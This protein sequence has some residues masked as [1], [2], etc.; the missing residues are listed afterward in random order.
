MN[1]KDPTEHPVTAAKSEPSLAQLRK[2]A[3]AHVAT[4]QSL[5]EAAIAELSPTQIKTLV[6]E[7]Q[8]HQVELTQQNEALQQTQTELERLRTRYYDLYEQAPVG[9][10]TV[11]D[12]GIIQEANR[13]A[14]TLLGL[15]RYELVGRPLSRFIRAQDKV[16]DF[17]H[18]RALFVSGDP[19]TYEIKLIKPNGETF[20]ARFDTSL[21]Q[22]EDFTPVSRVTISDITRRR[23]S[24]SALQASEAKFRGIFDNLQDAVFLH[25]VSE[26]QGVGR[27]LDVNPAACQRLGYTP[28]E[29]RQLTPRDVEE[30][31]RFEQHVAEVMR[32]LHQQGYALFETVH[33]AKDGRRIPVENHTRLFDIGEQRLALTIS[34]DIA[35]RRQLLHDLEERIKELKCLHGIAESIR[36]RTDIDAICQDIVAL[37]PPGWHY[38][39]ITRGKITLAD[40]VYVTEPFDETPWQLS[41]EIVVSGQSEGTVEVYYLRE[42][43]ELDEGPFLHE[44]RQLIDSIA[45]SLG[46]AIER[47]R[48]EAQYRQFKTI[49]DFAV[50]GTGIAGLDGTLLYVNESFARV[51]GY[52]P[53]ELIGRNLSIF[54]SDQQLSAVSRVNKKLFHEGRFGP[55]EIGHIHRDGSE[56]PMLMSGILIRD[57]HNQPQY[58]AASAVDIRERKQAEQQL[59]LINQHLQQQIARANQLAQQAETANQAKSGFLASMSHEIRTPINAIIG[60]TGLLLDT[61]LSPEQHQYADTVRSSSQALL[62][63]I[64]DILDLSKIEAGK[65]ELDDVIFDLPKLLDEL[66]QIIGA[67]ARDKGLHFHC[68]TEP[69]VP[70]QLQGDPGRLRQILINLASNAVKFTA[71]GQVTVRVEL[72]EA[73]AEGTRLRFIVRDTGIGIPRAKQDKLFKNFS[74]IDTSTTRNFGGTGLG[75]AIAKQLTDAMGGEIG[76]DSEAD[77]GADFWFT[78][79][80]QRARQAVSPPASAEPPAKAAPAAAVIDHASVLVVDDNVINLKVAAGVL[81]KL[82]VKAEAVESGHAALQALRL[83]SFDMVLMDVEM[84]DMDGLSAT[85]QIRDP[86][87]QVLNPRIPVIALTAHAMAG[88]REKCLAAGMDGYVPK[89]IEPQTLREVIERWL[90]PSR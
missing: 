32:E 71:A 46:Q 80:F 23:H 39:D 3:E 82:G 52:S 67:M 14:T 2:Q 83:Q 30:P 88:D 37:I 90:T 36:T 69:E 16:T 55:E 35:E 65:L 62:E 40:Q 33:I 51:H 10:C 74:Q 48:A 84:P 73:T 21:A 7:L 47:Q 86:A 70:P 50:H 26:D 58:I 24:E 8:I 11:T 9:Y 27:F 75:L 68:E 72:I 15:S 1:P 56:F 63:L 41:S 4:D 77:K 64:N 20:W 25:E 45:T 42:Q 13:T 61:S 66:S 79:Y 31:P 44:E 59:K 76:V 81:K 78:A 29:M 28:E 85:R 89:P 87:S 6:E 19:Q 53:D 43:P 17:M 57:Q 60:M 49:T 38:P 12:K 18:R 22:E 54:H 5:S 34:R